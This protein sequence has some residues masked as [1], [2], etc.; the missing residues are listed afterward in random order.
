MRD[1]VENIGLGAIV[2]T[3]IGIIFFIAP[4]LAVGIGWVAGIIIKWLF[5][6]YITN[7]LN[8]LFNTTR[9]TPESIPMIC[10]VLAVIGSYFKSFTNGK[11]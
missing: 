2:T 10:S 7:G 3:I 6:T 9:F 11:E 1:F 5:G 4:V 8:L